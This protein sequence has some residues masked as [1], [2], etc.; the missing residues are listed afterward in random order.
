MFRNRITFNTGMLDYPEAPV[1]R[2]WDISISKS[3]DILFQKNRQTY[4][5]R[6]KPLNDLFQLFENGPRN[7]NIWIVWNKKGICLRQQR[8]ESVTFSSKSWKS[9]E[10]S[11]MLEFGSK[12][13]SAQE[14]H[15]GKTGSH[16][17]ISS[18]YRHFVR[19]PFEEARFRCWAYKV[20]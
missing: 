4:L 16:F 10:I 20:I 8:L 1:S 13:T 14:V 15:D 11:L 17:F 19:H 5:L 12:F 9:A 18:N 6:V 2:S 3:W 7:K